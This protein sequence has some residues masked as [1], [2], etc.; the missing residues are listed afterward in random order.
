[1]GQNQT[2][3]RGVNGELADPVTNDPTDQTGVCGRTKAAEQGNGHLD[4]DARHDQDAYQASGFGPSISQSS[5][6]SINQSTGHP[7]NQP[8][9]QPTSHPTSHPTNWSYRPSSHKRRLRRSC[10]RGSR[11]GY[12]M[13]SGFV[14]RLVVQV[15]VV[16]EQTWTE[17]V[18]H[19]NIPVTDPQR[20]WWRPLHRCS[21]EGLGSET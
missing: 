7:A 9:N 5:H 13:P 4:C 6:Q 16:G 1:M 18:V 11:I 17:I 12:H 14:C 3:H 2:D 10:R 15:G 8:T 19:L 21:Q 20:R